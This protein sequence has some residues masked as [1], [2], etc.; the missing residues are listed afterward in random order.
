M[1]NMKFKLQY[2][3]FAMIA[4]CVVFTSCIEDSVSTSPS[5]QPTFSVDTLRLGT[6]FTTDGSPTSRFTVYNRH[7][8]VIS[9]GSI[10]LRDDAGNCFRLNVDG[11]TGRTFSNVEIR[12]NDSIFVFVETT[13]PLNGTPGTTK[14]EAHLDFVTAG[15][16]RTVVLEAE[17][18]DVARRRGYVVTG[19]ETWSADY[20]YQIFDSLIVAEGA[21][22]TLDAGVTLNFHDA[23]YMRIDGTLITKGTADRPV[24]FVGDRTGNVVSSIP[25]EIMSGQWDGVVFTTTSRAN[26]LS[27]TSIRNTKYGVIVDSV[28]ANDL[29]ALKLVN[30]QLRNSQQYA[31]AAIHSD[32]TAIGCE[33]AD[34]SA[35]VVY[36]QGGK[37]LFNHCTIA[38][39]YLFTALGGASVQFAHYNADSDDDSGLPFMDAQFTNSIIY[40][41]GLD[42]SE[43]DFTGTSVTLD[44]CILKSD[45]SDDDNFIS[46]LWDTDPMYYTVREEYYFDYR[47]MPES[48][49]IGAANAAL[50]HAEAAVDRLGVSRGSS[51]A[52]GAYEPRVAD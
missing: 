29:P 31:L 42:L 2:I 48:P 34:A 3:F 7:D 9:I 38:N 51:P 30:C 44:T 11:L 21:R 25:Y 37:H 15:V 22:L 14:R 39:Y 18:Q 16:T 45:G 50:T 47:P 13:L 8:K 46:C 10:A 12:P 27:H 4:A 19:T 33:L 5:D 20:P 28:P 17:G 24:N 32:I 43:G 6:V 40:G 26:E 49:A 41:N 36:L 23:S 35:G 1:K 52:I